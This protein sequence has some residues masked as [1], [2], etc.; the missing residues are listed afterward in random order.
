[1]RF[2]SDNT[3]SVSPQILE[4]IAAAN[5]GLTIGYGEDPWTRRLDFELRRKRAGHLLPQSRFVEPGGTGDASLRAAG[6]GF[7]HWRSPASGAARLVA[8]WDQDGRHVEA[9]CAALAAV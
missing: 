3:A 9:L 2:S 6:C 1:M 7:Y 4:A 8:S 5:H